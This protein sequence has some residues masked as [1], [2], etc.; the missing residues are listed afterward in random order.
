VNWRSLLF[1]PALFCLCHLLILQILQEFEA[2][3]IESRVSRLTGID[4]DAEEQE[5]NE[6]KI[7]ELEVIMSE[8][9]AAFNLLTAQNQR[10]E[11]YLFTW[12]INRRS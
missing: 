10:S 2:H 3:M 1:K 8:K 11:V 9:L 6:K 7:A 5:A 4:Q 12:I